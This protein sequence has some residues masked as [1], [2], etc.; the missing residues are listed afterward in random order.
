[1]FEGDFQQRRTRVLIADEMALI[2]AGTRALLEPDCDVVGTVA[3]GRA[4][5]SEAETLRP[6]II[7]MEILL[8]LLNGLDALR[9][10]VRKV[11]ESKIVLLTAQESS[12][13]VAEAFKAGASGYVLKRSQPSELTQAIHAVLMGQW[14]LTPLI[15]K[16]VVKQDVGGE[17]PKR[18]VPTVST[19]TPRQ[20]EV[21]QLIAEGRGTKEVA[22]LLNIAVKTVEFHKFR[23]MDQL[24]LHSTVALAKHAIIEGLVRL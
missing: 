8:P 22:T 13:H 17:Q 3:D 14:Y 19:L 6:D 2:A 16:N 1:M 18:K 11:P 12:W 9:P 5:L 15:A 24:N 10:L 23:I 4:L 21:L 20:R 7:V